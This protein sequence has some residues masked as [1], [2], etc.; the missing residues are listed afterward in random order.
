MEEFLRSYGLWILLAGVFVA[1]HWFGR[2]YG[3]GHRHGALRDGGAVSA[4]EKK[5]EA[6]HPGSRRGCH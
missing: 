4:E 6:A 5:R 1:I 2:G 3:D